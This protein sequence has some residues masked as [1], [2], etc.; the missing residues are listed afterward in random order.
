M[1]LG[2]RAEVDT[3]ARLEVGARGAAYQSDRRA[4]RAQQHEHRPLV[5]I[6]GEAELPKGVAGFT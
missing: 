3:F 4:P 1:R 2:F 5:T 6:R